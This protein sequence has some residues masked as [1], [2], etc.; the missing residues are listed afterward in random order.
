MG[1]KK[2]LKEAIYAWWRETCAHRKGLV[3]LEE[4]IEARE[5]AER[6]RVK[7][8]LRNVLKIREGCGSIDLVIQA[9]Y[10]PDTLPAGDYL[11]RDKTG[12]I[13]FERRSHEFPPTQGYEYK[14]IT[15]PFE[16]Q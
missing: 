13:W 7:Q 11:V 16:V 10:P 12:R 3:E 14:Q 6:E 5:A 2:L 9:L 1:S 4:L 8:T 15:N